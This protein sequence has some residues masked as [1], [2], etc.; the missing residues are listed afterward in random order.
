MR[1]SLGAKRSRPTALRP[2]LKK[3]AASRRGSS[4][5]RGEGTSVSRGKAA[6]ERLARREGG[7]WVEPKEMRLVTSKEDSW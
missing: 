1:C 5:Q 6:K 3:K 2:E 4:S 7:G